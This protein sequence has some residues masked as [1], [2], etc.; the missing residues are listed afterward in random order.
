MLIFVP[1]D[2]KLSPSAVAGLN[3]TMGL[4]HGLT[5]DLGSKVSRSAYHQSLKPNNTVSSI[6]Y[7]Y[8]RDPIIYTSNI[9]INSL[10]M[11]DTNYQ[12]DQLL[13]HRALIE[14]VISSP[15][16]TSKSVFPID[17]TPLLGNCIP[18]DYGSYTTPPK[19]SVNSNMNLTEFVRSEFQINE[20]VETIVDGLNSLDDPNVTVQTSQALDTNSGPYLAPMSQNNAVLPEANI[21]V[22]AIT[23]P[24][25]RLSEDTIITE[26]QSPPPVDN[27]NLMYNTDSINLGDSWNEDFTELDLDVTEADFDFFKTPAP[28]ASALTDNVLNIIP[29]KN[30]TEEKTPVTAIEEPEDVIMEEVN[31]P[32]R[33][34][35]FTPFVMSNDVSE[36]ISM[37]SSNK[38]TVE[39]MS[40]NE[41]VPQKKTPCYK[42]TPEHACFVPPGFLPVPINTAAIDAKYE[43]GGKFNYDPSMN[44]SES[45][46]FKKDLYSPDYMPS[47]TKKRKEIEVVQGNINAENN[48]DIEMTDVIQPESNSSNASNSVNSSSSSSVSSSSS[49]S[50]D[51]SDKDDSNSNSENLSEKSNSSDLYTDED[52]D[53]EDSCNDSSTMDQMIDKRLRSLKK[54]QKSVI[55][56]LLKATPASLPTDRSRNIDYDTPFAPVLADGNIKPI[57]WR[58]SKTMEKSM[59]YLCQQAIWGGYPFTGGLAEVS[60]NGGEFEVESSKIM[61]ARRTNIMQMTRGVVTHVPSLPVDAH[62]LTIRFKNMLKHIFLRNT[63]VEADDMNS[64]LEEEI[65]LRPTSYSNT[66]TLGSIDVKG[67]LTIQQYYNLNGKYS[68][69]F[70][71]R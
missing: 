47:T 8:Y 28:V 67:P 10:S 40:T 41:L 13:L 30:D 39:F 6:D 37:N 38:P 3:G 9:M 20:H 18:T 58:Q 27:Y 55:Y 32:N 54:F 70:V 42:S 44:K 2:T 43:P 11:M 45:H 25:V 21:N 16:M 53:T 22:N 7:W 23:I 51:N 34:S 71:K 68:F 65:S 4:N 36:D 19:S 29:I 49:N 48:I 63:S 12:Q 56:S 62:K 52:S 69:I 66:P 59:E 15:I 17:T 33:D 46:N 57:K 64:L 60:E 24:E 14:P 50:S 5:E 61:M 26:Q 35:L 31:T 1:T